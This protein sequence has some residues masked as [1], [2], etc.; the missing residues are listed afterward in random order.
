M[1]H[2][3]GLDSLREELR[4]TGGDATCI[5]APADALSFLSL[6]LPP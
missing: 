2:I 3:E 4:P 1:W 5:A 6:T